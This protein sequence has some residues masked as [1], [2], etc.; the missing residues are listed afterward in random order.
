MGKRVIRFDRN[1][2]A[3]PM[4][5]FARVQPPDDAEEQGIVAMFENNRYGVILKVTQSMGW[6][7]LGPDNKPM[8]MEIMHVIIVSSDKKHG[9]PWKDVQR[10]KSEILG[11][12]V[13]ALELYPSEARRIENIPDHQTH[14]WVLPPGEFLPVGLIP[15]DMQERIDGG[16][17]VVDDELEV[18]VVEDGDFYQVFANEQDARNGYGDKDMPGGAFTKIE[19]A[20]EEGEGVVWSESAKMMMANIFAKADA[21]SGDNSDAVTVDTNGPKTEQDEIEENIGVSDESPNSDEEGV[22]MPEFM[23]MGVEQMQKE[24]VSRLA[25][26]VKVLREHMTKVEEKK[27]EEEV[28]DEDE[29][30]EARDDLRKMREEMVKDKK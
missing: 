12:N 11:D 20:N 23:A 24:R 13:E 3:G 6:Q 27:V 9:P 5:P 1:K 2:K 16:I 18:F 4:T 28:V 30:Q 7:M 10:I 22:M 17:V 8:P 19:D 14:L 21:L 26:S 25:S 15:K 29:E